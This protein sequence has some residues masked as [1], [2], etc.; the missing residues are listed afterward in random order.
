MATKIIPPGFSQAAIQFRHDTY[1]RPAVCVFG[2]ASPPVQPSDAV[3]RV[4]L[5]VETTIMTRMDNQVG[6]HSVRLAVGTSGGDPI[7][8]ETFPTKKG[9]VNRSSLPPALAL[10]VIKTTG[11]GGRRG[12]GAMFLPWAVAE[13][14]VDEVG[15]VSNGEVQAWSNA[16]NDFKDELAAQECDLVLLHAE[17][18]SPAPP[19]T[20]VLTVGVDPIISNQVRRQV[21]R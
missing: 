4:A 12:R 1:I 14:Q 18:V 17:G 6:L 9:D 19:P 13:N 5:A 15:N 10:R 3:M 16:M 8:A 2:I 20:P 11:L 21:R 7:V